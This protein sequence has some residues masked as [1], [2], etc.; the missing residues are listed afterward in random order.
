[1]DPLFERRQLMKKVHI[2]SKFLQKNIQA[3]ILAQLRMH[4]EGKCLAEG[5]IHRGSINIMNYSLG[6]TNYI[7][8][9]IDYDVI[10]QADI[11]LPHPGQHFKAEVTVRSQ[12]GIHAQLDPIKILIPRDINIGNPIFENVKVGDFIEFEVIG[13]QFKQQDSNIIV[14]GRLSG[15]PKEEKVEV[16]AAVPVLAPT[17]SES[18]KSVTITPTTT[19]DA[20]K[21]KTRRL[22]Q[23]GAEEVNEHTLAL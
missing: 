17:T 9:G 6:R 2:H 1:M 7:K 19:T 8:G 12:I 4:Y 23:G 13:C 18:E 14:I 20:P 21:R 10:F 16:Q 3:S 15:I 11:C 5:F 22:K